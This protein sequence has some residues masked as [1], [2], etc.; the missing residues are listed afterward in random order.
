MPHTTFALVG[1]AVPSPD[2]PNHSGAIDGCDEVWRFNNAPGFAG[3]KQGTRTS[4]LWLVNSG[5]SM[6]ERLE[7]ADFPYHPVMRATRHLAFPVH[8]SMLRRYHPEPNEEEREGGDRNDWTGPAIERFG[9]LGWAI[10]VLPA[11]HYIEACEA[12]KLNEDERRVRFPSTGF[13]A[14]HWLLSTNPDAHV[15]TFGFTW[16][17]WSS[18]SWTAE[19]DWF[20]RQH[21][22]GRVEITL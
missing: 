9:E 11:T 13:L 19:R 5:G 8:P 2:D 17:G 22:A 15:R 4:L 12:L 1:N 3:G 7:M 16:Q 10:T 14:A 6:R 21:Q 20:E 18:H